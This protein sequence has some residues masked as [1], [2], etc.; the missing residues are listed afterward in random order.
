MIKKLRYKFIGIAS[1]AV[2]VVLF[3]VFLLVIGASYLNLR[4]QTKAVTTV[5]S[6]NGGKM[7]V[8]TKKETID[9]MTQESQYGTRYFSVILDDEGNIGSLSDDQIA[10]I[11]EDDVYKLTNKAAKRNAEYGFIKYKTNYYSYQKN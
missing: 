11:S 9:F 4:M 6:E 7:M 8:D 2:L 10:I 3:F 1:F 5:I